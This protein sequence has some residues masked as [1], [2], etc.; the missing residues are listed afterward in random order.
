MQSSGPV[1]QPGPKFRPGRFLCGART[2]SAGLKSD[3]ED[4]TAMYYALSAFGDFFIT[5][6]YQ[7]WERPMSGQKWFT[8][9]LEGT[10]Q[11]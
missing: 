11:I 9:D 3:S 6:P 1:A 2:K 10:Y 7:N 4:A 8:P 5:N